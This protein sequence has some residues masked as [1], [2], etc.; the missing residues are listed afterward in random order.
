MLA[1]SEGRNLITLRDILLA[2]KAA[3]EWTSNLAKVAQ[4]IVASDWQRETDAVE[5]Y[6]RSRPDGEER[7]ERVLRAFKQVEGPKLEMYIQSLI[8][9]GRIYEFNGKNAGKMLGIKV[10]DE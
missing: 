3:E 7:K 4:Q 5:S 2:L 8:N 9:Q 10:R 6:I 1:L